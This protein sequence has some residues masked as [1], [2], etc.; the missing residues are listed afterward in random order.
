MIEW[1]QQ[2]VL[3]YRGNYIESTHQLHIA[4]VDSDG[5]LLYAYGDDTRPIFPR[6][7]MKPFQAIPLVETGAAEYFHYSTRELAISCASHNAE[8]I[9]RQTVL[10]I[11]KKIGLTEAALQC[12]THPPYDEESY[13]Q[14]IKEGK[15]LTPLCSNCSGKHSGMLA[16][17]V[18][19]H[20]DTATYREVV[21]PVQQRILSAI[22]DVCEVPTERIGF[23]VDGCGAPVHR[24]PL[25]NVAL[26]YAKLATG[27]G[28]H[29]HALAQLRDAMMADPYMIG[30]KNSFDT[31]IM[32]AC[33][34]RILA[35]AGAEGV[36]CLADVDQGL[37]IAI[38][39]EDGNGRARDTVALHVLQQIGFFGKDEPIPDPLTN[40]VV[41]PI[42]NRRNE[43]VGKIVVNFALTKNK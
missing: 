28:I 42:E 8:L 19:M 23:G 10:G 13:I 32:S 14:L 6:S 18:Y 31:D 43:T 1:E 34:N 20:E 36:L 29:G 41:P 5:Q 9:H 4:V 39:I 17:A 21:H 35:K 27:T 15:S 33:P 25:A 7:S 26:G 12:G 22:A 2:P 24:L 37:G 30:G 3:V 38:K 40:Y 16:T 11:L